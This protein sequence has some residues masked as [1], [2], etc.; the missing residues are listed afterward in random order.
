MHVHDRSR[1]GDRRG[2]SP[3]VARRLGRT[4]DL[5]VERLRHREVR[6]RIAVPP[7]QDPAVRRH[8]RIGARQAR[9][10]RG[11][12]QI[13]ARRR[14]RSLHR[15]PVAEGGARCD[16]RRAAKGHAQAPSPRSSLQGVDPARGTGG[17][18]ES[19]HPREGGTR[20]MTLGLVGDRGRSASCRTRAACSCPPPSRAVWRCGAPSGAEAEVCPGGTRLIA[21]WALACGR[22]APR[23]L[24]HRHRPRRTAS[25]LLQ[26][27]AFSRSL[28]G[29]S[30]DHLR[31]LAPNAGAPCKTVGVDAPKKSYDAGTSEQRTRP[32][33]LG[34]ISPELALVDDVLAERARMLLPDPTERTRPPRVVPVARARRFPSGRRRPGRR[35]VRGGEAA[36]AGRCCSRGSC[37]LQARPPAA[38]SVERRRRYPAVP[39]EAEVKVPTATRATDTRTQALSEPTST[40]WSVRP[41]RLS[42]R[43]VLPAANVLGV[44]T[45]VTRRG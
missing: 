22:L 31:D 30:P 27:A 2:E 21:S 7:D 28:D 43:A 26:R 11:D 44:T 1:H 35:R 15:E 36:G 6:G 14:R 33:D 34:P 12:Q 32:H 29:I 37:S 9:V 45:A 10:D 38:S 17:G 16:V 42:G 41:A 39:F 18:D 8:D 40:R 19:T 4:G 5:V 20:L 3:A 13:S 25:R 23:L 24:H